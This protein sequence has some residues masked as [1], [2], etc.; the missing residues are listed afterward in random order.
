MSRCPWVKYW[1][2]NCCRCRCRC[3][4]DVLIASGKN[5]FHP[6]SW[7]LPPGFGYLH[8]NRWIL[9]CK[10]EHFEVKINWDTLKI[11]P[12]LG[13][14]DICVLFFF[15]DWD[16]IFLNLFL[17]RALNHEWYLQYINTTDII[18]TENCLVLYFW[19]NDELCRRFFANFAGVSA[20][21]ST[22]SNCFGE[23]GGCVCEGTY[24]RLQTLNK[25]SPDKHSSFS[26]KQNFSRIILW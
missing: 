7:A 14:N 19:L 1:T 16:S 15:F 22:C 18:L 17:T 25:F 21:T 2:P 13:P 26:L 12:R 24:K 10:V 4:V 20:A 8:V 23:E 11:Q 3:F 6:A 5:R 9:I